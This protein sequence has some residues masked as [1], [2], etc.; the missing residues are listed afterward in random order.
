MIQEPAATWMIF[1]LILTGNRN[2]ERRLDR[3]SQWQSWHRRPS[4]E[5]P[6]GFDR[7]VP[8]LW[9]RSETRNARHCQMYYAGWDVT[10]GLFVTVRRICFYRV[11]FSRQD[12][13]LPEMEVHEG[14]LLYHTQNQLA[15]GGGGARVG[16]KLSDGPA[17]TKRYARRRPTV[18]RRGPRR[19]YYDDP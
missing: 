11:C 17:G 7:E 4:R 8:C 9:V 2:V 10:R 5:R 6:R 15:Q 16:Q 12:Y 18:F 3:K 1:R 19:R 14:A 13:F